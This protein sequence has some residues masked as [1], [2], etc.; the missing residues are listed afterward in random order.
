MKIRISNLI[1]LIVIIPILSGIIAGAST[2]VSQGELKKTTG[3]FWANFSWSAGMNT[4]S[5]NVSIN[6]SIIKYWTNGTKNTSINITSVPHG[7][8]YIEVWGYNETDQILSRFYV[9]KA[10]ISNNKIILTDVSGS[11]VLYEGETL[12]IDANYTDADNDT[13]IFATTA[14][15]G[16]FDSSTGVLLW[17]TVAGDG[18]RDGITYPRWIINVTD[19]IRSSSISSSQFSVTVYQ[20]LP[21]DPV[22]LTR[23]MGNFWVNYTWA[24]GANTDSYNISINGDWHNNT[25]DPFINTSSLPHHWVNI[26]VAGYNEASQLLSNF[27]SM[28]TQIQNNPISIENVEDRY[29][30]NE[31]DTLIIDADSF[32]MDGDKGIFA[33]DAT[34]GTF[35]ATTGILK[36]TTSPGDG[37]VYIWSI[38]VSDGYDSISTKEFKV[39]IPP[40]VVIQ[41]TEP[42]IINNK[43]EWVKSKIGHIGKLIGVEV[44]FNNTGEAMQFLNIT[45]VYNNTR[46][47]IPQ[48]MLE[49]GSTF[50]YRK[51]FSINSSG[52]KNG[53]FTYSFEIE[54][55]GFDG[56]GYTFFYQN[57]T[58]VSLPILPI[59]KMKRASHDAVYVREGSTT[60]PIIY[61]LEANSSMDMINVSIYDPFYPE[62]QGGPYFNI[63][64]LEANKGKSINYSYQVT[65]ADSSKNNCEQPYN[66]C[67]L[68]IAAFSGRIES[69]DKEINDTEFVRIPVAAI[70]NVASSGSGNSGSGGGGGGGGLPPSEDF[71]NIERREVR[72]MSTLYGTLTAY[73]FRSA[74]PVIAVTFES[75]V[76]QNDVPVAVE[77]LKNRSKKIS[78]DPPANIYKYF[79]VFV[80]T[81]GFSKKVSK[82]IIVYRVNN[83]WIQENGLKPRDIY[84][85]KWDGN[86]W[87]KIATEIVESNSNRTSF[88]SLVGNFS[89]FAITGIKNETEE[90]NMFSPPLNE[91][92]NQTV[93]SNVQ[94]PQSMYFIILGI[95]IIGILGIVYYKKYKNKK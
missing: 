94:Q 29:L 27:V 65:T 20:S 79:N 49:K 67:I 77:V 83:S 4:D 61:T 19:G 62:N 72:E 38:N 86:N 12:Y 3:N 95:M 26:S 66:S 48:L 39:I 32:D 59:L 76:S 41:F 24:P 73:I 30:L 43:E 80:G 87:V 34:R 17:E 5:Y 18:S 8:I 16:S 35:N 44:K 90:I 53:L 11:Y 85:S 89:S 57:I 91:S 54:S 50:S 40:R 42:S 78:V 2:P 63:S 93:G 23:S 6:N 68:N 33:T 55:E 21:G 10:E 52:I 92:I 1:V 64:K 7:I 58:T 75:S 37:G 74:D 14:T 22:R 47:N 69:S 46:T 9:D 82:G 51:E 25:R 84:L 70:S 31:G 45:E 28:R 56:N 88:A 13:G 36:W 81:S 71:N 15:K 60:P